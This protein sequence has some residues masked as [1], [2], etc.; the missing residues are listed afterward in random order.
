[1]RAR[2]FNMCYIIRAQILFI[3]MIIL[4]N[5]AFQGLKVKVR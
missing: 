1:M 2:N 4:L 5:A 3:S